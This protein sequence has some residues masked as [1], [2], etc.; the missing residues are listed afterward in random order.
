MVLG[1][2]LL[3]SLWAQQGAFRIGAALLPQ[4]SFLFNA[5]DA[6]AGSKVI[7]RPLTLGFAGGLSASYHFTDNLGVGLDVL[8]SNQGQRYQGVS[9]IRIDEDTTYFNIPVDYTARTTLNYLKVPAYF[10]F[11]TNPNAKVFFT[12][13]LGPQVNL[14]MSYKERLDGKVE[15]GFFSIPFSVTASGK[16]I[17]GKVEVDEESVEG[18]FTALPYRNFLFGLAGGAGIGI[19]LT[20]NLLLSLSLRTDYTF[21]DAENK[22]AKVEGTDRDGEPLSYKFWSRQHKYDANGALALLVGEAPPNYNRAPT[23]TMT[24][25]LQIGV[26]YV[27]GR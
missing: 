2:L 13:F 9:Y 1:A 25:G 17:R 12:A 3:G 8:F 11:N 19:S 27:I 14:F 7:G 16:T 26:Y 4:S 22:E 24:V 6:K 10:Y 15:F 18:K 23:T 20:Y 5:D 21:G